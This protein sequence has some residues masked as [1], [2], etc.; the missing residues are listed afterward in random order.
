MTALEGHV[1]VLNRRKISTCDSFCLSMHA[2]I[3]DVYV[4]ILVCKKEALNS[5]LL[6]HHFSLRDVFMRL[7]FSLLGAYEYVLVVD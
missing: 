5:P 6:V 3:P 2:L 1:C 7:R 4:L